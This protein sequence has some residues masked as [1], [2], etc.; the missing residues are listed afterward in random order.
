MKF[1]SVLDRIYCLEPFALSLSK[2]VFFISVAIATAYFKV[3]SRTDSRD[4]FLCA[5]KEKC[6]GQEF[7]DSTIGSLE[8]ISDS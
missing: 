8:V 5:A 7:S 6:S 2:G 4:T 1:K 3:G